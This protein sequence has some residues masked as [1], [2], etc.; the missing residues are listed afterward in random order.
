MTTADSHRLAREFLAA[1]GRGH[2][3][4][5]LVTPDMTAWTLSGGD[6]DLA[7]FQAGVKLLAAVVAGELVYDIVAI[8]A[9]DDR[10]VAEVTSDWPLVNGERARNHHVFAFRVREGRICHMA[11][12]MDTAVPR[13]ILGPAIQGLVAQMQAAG[14]AGGKDSGDDNG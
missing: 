14:Q 10:L 8:T 11:E 1:V 5:E 12:Y 4:E 3:P 7:R 13:D 2:L 6:A 9:E